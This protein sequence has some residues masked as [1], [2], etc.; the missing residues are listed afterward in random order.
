MR[1]QLRALGKT[2]LS[3]SAIKYREHLY[4]L[5]QHPEEPLDGWDARDSA[6]MVYGSVTLFMMGEYFAEISVTRAPSG[7]LFPTGYVLFWAFYYT[8]YRPRTLSDSLALPSRSFMMAWLVSL[9]QDHAEA[10][11][12]PWLHLNNRKIT[13][14]ARRKAKAQTFTGTKHAKARETSSARPQAGA[15]KAQAKTGPSPSGGATRQA[16]TRPILPREVLSAL[17][18]LELEAEVDWAIVHHRYRVLAKRFHPDL[19][20]GNPR[21][22]DRFIEI[23]RAYHTLE[24]LKPFLKR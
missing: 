4:L 23:D 20:P 18:V 2:D 10:F 9:A 13:P 15:A 6:G 19:N 21:L 17:K 7:L 24:K 5:K 14:K 8:F 16:P 11:R 3:N 12:K 1:P 22:R